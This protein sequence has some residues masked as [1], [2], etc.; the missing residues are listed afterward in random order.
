MLKSLL[1]IKNDTKSK[2]AW[3]TL[4]KTR[5]PIL[6]P[7]A[8]D[9]L[10]AR[11]IERLG[12]C[13]YQVGGF[14][15]VGSRH[16]FPDIDLCH[17]GEQHDGLRDIMEGSTLPVLIDADDGYGDVKN[18]TRTI[19]GYEALGASA[20]FF[21]DQKAPK[22]C[23]HME[24][25]EVIPKADMVARVRAAAAARNSR[26][27][28]LIART[29]ARYKYGLDDAMRRADAYLGAGADGVFIEA[30]QS[31]AELETIGKYFK[32]VHKIANMLEGGG[33]T[34][35]LPPQELHQLGF[36][37]VT[38]PTTVL[39]RAAKAIERALIDIRDGVPM[40]EDD[41]VDFAGFEA[42]VDKEKWSNLE[43]RFGKGG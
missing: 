31:V 6:L 27:T 3:K 26:K 22:R 16:A 10:T 29:D 14:A 8:H 1:R 34:P 33:K 18:I 20:L 37:M 4:L 19:Q 23:G 40:P 43:K 35:I 2:P 41:S 36:D 39:F 42:I 24:D 25:K 30:P 7:A 9:A 5:A 12:F 32:G 17:Y 21:E 28:F 15:L 11:L 13:A 38:Y